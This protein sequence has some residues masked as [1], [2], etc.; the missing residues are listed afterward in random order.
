MCGE[1][2]YL[3]PLG[4]PFPGGILPGCHSDVLSRAEALGIALVAL[5]GRNTFTEN[6]HRM[7]YFDPAQHPV[8]A[9][10]IN[11]PGKRRR[12][13]W[14]LDDPSAKGSVRGRKGYARDQQCE[15]QSEHPAHLHPDCDAKLP[16]GVLPPN[17][18]STALVI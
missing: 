2:Q 18:T 14:R 9:L 1:M 5:A 10:H 15:D 16:S 3:H 8:P 13:V 7:R 17:K 11:P 12:V 4:P 6:N